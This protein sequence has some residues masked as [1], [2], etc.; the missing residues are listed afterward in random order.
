MTPVQPQPMA[1]IPA[2]SQVIVADITVATCGEF[3]GDL[4]ENFVIKPKH[5]DIFTLT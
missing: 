3:N 1:L 4:I 2:S 5:V